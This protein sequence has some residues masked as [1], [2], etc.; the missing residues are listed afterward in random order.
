MIA[1]TEMDQANKIFADISKANIAIATW[2]DPMSPDADE[3]GECSL[4]VKGL[5][6][7]KRIV[8]TDKSEV[9]EVYFF[10]VND[11]ATAHM[12]KTN[13]GDDDAEPVQ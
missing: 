10:H 8:A 11:A 3:N 12:V 5:W 6:R 9:A 13:F 7:L 2:F 1:P 4:I